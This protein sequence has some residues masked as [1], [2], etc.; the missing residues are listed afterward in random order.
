MIGIGPEQFNVIVGDIVAFSQYSG[1]PIRE[2]G[3]GENIIILD[4]SEIILQATPESDAY[5]TVLL[6][7]DVALFEDLL[8]IKDIVQHV[9]YNAAAHTVYIKAIRERIALKEKDNA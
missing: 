9:Y 7:Y 5:E 8:D 6:K 3:K 2:S 1:V 4:D